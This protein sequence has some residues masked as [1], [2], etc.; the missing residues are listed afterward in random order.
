MLSWPTGSI[1]NGGR[2][3]SVIEAFM[4]VFENLNGHKAKFVVCGC[5][6]NL[7]RRGRRRNSMIELKL[8][9]ESQVI[10]SRSL[11]MFQCIARLTQCAELTAGLDIETEKLS[12]FQLFFAIDKTKYQMGRII[13]PGQTQINKSLA[14]ATTMVRFRHAHCDLVVCRVAATRLAQ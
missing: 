7:K 10:L 3:G 12:M 14:N 1:G 2:R 13:I 6:G 5:R 11:E 9:S 4:H 8:I